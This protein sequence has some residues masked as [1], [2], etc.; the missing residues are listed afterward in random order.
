MAITKHNSS[1]INWGIETEGMPFKKLSEL[2][3]GKVYTL[4]GCFATPDNGY[5]PGAV[6]ITDDALINVPQRYVDLVQTIR[7]DP[8]DIEQ[9][10]EGK[11]GFRYSVFQSQKY[12]NKGYGI[13]L[14]DL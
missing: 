3:E 6:L 11:A 5:G 4:R 14:V 7:N 9:I 8:D 12:K 2:E 1:V 10:K 13:D